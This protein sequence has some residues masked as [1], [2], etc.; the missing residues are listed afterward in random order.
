MSIAYGKEVKI[1]LSS[2]A[3]FREN[4]LPATLA[5]EIGTHFRRYLN[6]RELGLKIF[7]FGTGYYLSDE[8]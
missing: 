6:G 4:E 7:Q 2:N 8:E 1:K 5:H 3:I